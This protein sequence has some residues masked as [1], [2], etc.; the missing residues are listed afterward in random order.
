MGAQATVRYPRPDGPS[1]SGGVMPRTTGLQI[2]SCDSYE[3]ERTRALAPR[4]GCRHTGS[5]VL[6]IPDVAVPRPRKPVTRAAAKRTY[7]VSGP[8]CFVDFTGMI[9]GDT[10]TFCQRG[11]LRFIY[12]V[13]LLTPLASAR[14]R[15]ER[16]RLKRRVVIKIQGPQMS[17]TG[18]RGE[19][20][21]NAGNNVPYLGSRRSTQPD[22]IREI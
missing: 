11:F 2:L 15:G 22:Q 3:H 17:P 7:P 4:N 16:E 19:S 5:M 14:Y 12:N 13:H 18:W 21:L 9:K 1:P 6:I 10:H 20:L 8:Y